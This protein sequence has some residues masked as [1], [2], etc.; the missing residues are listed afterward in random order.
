MSAVTVGDCIAFGSPALPGR[1]LREGDYRDECGFAR[2]GRCGG[3]RELPVSLLPDL[4]PVVV[5]C[6]CRCE[7]EAYERSHPQRAGIPRT[8]APL[9]AGLALPDT[10]K[11]TFELA[12]RKVGREHVAKARLY[13]ERFDEM[14]CGGTG[15][16]LFGPPSC[17]KT[18]V[19]CAVANLVRKGGHTVLATS[20]TRAVNALS[21]ARSGRNAA[22]DAICAR[23]LLV[24]DD[25][26]AER[27]GPVAREQAQALIDARYQS[28]R[29]LVVTTNLGL[30]HL[31]EETDVDKRRIYDRILE[32]CRPMA[33]PERN[34]R[35]EAAAA[36]QLQARELF[37]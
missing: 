9:P 22:M 28:G 31:R 20:M 36:N 33:L 23:Q 15:L 8:I 29:P 5:P 30:R 12:E 13:A 2:C 4:P 16:L 19:A 34:L 24:I 21:D 6:S 10:G 35:S 32:M 3:R 14:M 26:G 18:L 37:S 27:G 17:G 11:L 25:F 1:H 7:Q